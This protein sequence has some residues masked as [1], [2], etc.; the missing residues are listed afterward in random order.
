MR[1]PEIGDIYINS[2]GGRREVVEATEELIVIQIVGAEV[3]DAFR[4]SIWDRRFRMTPEQLNER[5]TLD[6]ITKTPLYKALN[7]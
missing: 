6:R 1:L 3:D 4:D 2:Q 7:G 5:Y